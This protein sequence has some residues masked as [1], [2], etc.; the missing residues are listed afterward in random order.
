[1]HFEASKELLFVVFLF[2]KKVGVILEEV[3]LIA[4]VMAAMQRK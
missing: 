3:T 2:V 1:V 4:G